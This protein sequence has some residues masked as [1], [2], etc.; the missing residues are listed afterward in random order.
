MR[1]SGK[2]D[3]TCRV[4][5]ADDQREVRSSLRRFMEKD[6][7]FEIVGEAENGAEAIDCVR[8]EQPD[9]LVLDL[10][11]PGVHGLQVLTQVMK[12]VPAIRVVVLSSMV[13]FNG[14]GPQAVAAGAV[15]AFDKYT[16]PKKVIKTLMQSLKTVSAPLECA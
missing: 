10:A 2:N 8:A 6:G 13:P 16:S 15:A 5:L 4:V 3:P 1:I 11:M 12:E 14:I 7:R 9:A